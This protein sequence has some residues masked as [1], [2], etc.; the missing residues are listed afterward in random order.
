MDDLNLYLESV[1]EGGRGSFAL[2]TLPCVVGRGSDCGLVLDFDRISRRHARFEVDE[3]GLRL[4][5]LGSTNG[6]FVNHQRLEGPTRISPGDTVHFANHGF[7]LRQRRSSGD[8]LL[9]RPPPGSRQSSDTMIGFT[10]LP[11]GFPVQAPEF[12]EL[13]NDEQLAASAQAV[14]TGS[15]LL[16]GHYIRPRSSHPRLAADA[17]NLFRLAED[18]GEESRLGEMSRRIC[19]ER[20]VEAGLQGTLFLLVH[21]VEFEDTE[22]L[23]DQLLPLSTRF[24]HL[25]IALELPTAAWSPQTAALRQRLRA[26]NF[27]LCYPLAPDQADA[28]SADTVPEADYVRC[29]WSAEGKAE[30]IAQWLDRCGTRSRLIVDGLVSQ[31]Q[32]VAL[33]ALRG[34]LLMGPAI[35]RAS[36]I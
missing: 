28:P 13:L 19:L 26:A 27:E 2:A 6:T 32:I 21:P 15:G 29:S 24:R 4:I 20:A 31:D 9:P 10:A 3:Q 30:R 5:D 12:F 23:V 1:D 33:K 34:L 35:G 16:M 8:T 11:T 17:A 7:Q 18:L 36:E 22:A 25:A 14:M